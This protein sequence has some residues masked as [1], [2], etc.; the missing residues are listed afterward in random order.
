MYSTYLRSAHRAILSRSTARW[1][2][3]LLV[4]ALLLGVTAMDATAQA[5]ADTTS[6]SR[7]AVGF[8]SSFPAFGVSAILDLGDQ[9]AVQGVLGAF[10][11]V[12]TFSGRGIYCF[13]QE[14]AYN[15]YGFGT[16]GLW[17]WS[18]FGISEN[19]VGVGGGG[20]I[21]LDW[22]AIFSPED[23]S[24]P[25]LVSSIDIGFTAA[26]FDNYNFN[27]LTIGAGLHYRF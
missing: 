4:G 20:G 3:L 12:S 1:A 14:R 19:S 5:A 10:G 6:S 23:G 2:P 25:P 9:I 22:R 24:F 8:Q 21:E 15:L 27:A 7:F 11:T 13:Q 16:V 26:N 18:G 17:R